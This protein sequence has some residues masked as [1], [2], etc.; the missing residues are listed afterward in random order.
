VL[1]CESSE[2]GQGVKKKKE[3]ALLVMIP[4]SSRGGIRV[5]GNPSLQAQVNLGCFHEWQV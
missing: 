2:G 5:A 3:V 4:E 1:P